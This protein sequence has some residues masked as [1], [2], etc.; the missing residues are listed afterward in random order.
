LY[1]PLNPHWY[2]SIPMIFQWS[3]PFK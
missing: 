2:P 3:V 1:S